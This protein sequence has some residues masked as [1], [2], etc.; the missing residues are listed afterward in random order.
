MSAGEVRWPDA[1]TYAMAARDTDSFFL[2][3]EFA[4]ATLRRSPLGLPLPAT[5]RNAAVFQASLGDGAV[6]VRVFTRPPAQG[7]ERY[8][9]IGQHLRELEGTVFP[10]VQWLSEAVAVE[11]AHW[12]MVRMDWIEGWTLDDWVRDHLDRPD[13]LLDLAQ[14][15]DE[16]FIYLDHSHIAHGDLQHGNV[17]IDADG[18]IKLVDLDGMWIPA[19]EAIPAQEYGHAHFQHPGRADDRIWNARMDG[20]AALLIGISVRALARRPELWETYNDGGNNLIFLADDFEDLER[21]IWADLLAIDDDRLRFRIEKLRR[22]CQE[23]CARLVG[24]L[25]MLNDD[26]PD[27]VVPGVPQW[28][29]AAMSPEPEPAPAPPATE[30]R[31]PVWALALAV[32]AVIVLAVVGVVVLG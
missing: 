14:S 22:A 7:P 23:D 3:P 21:P 16:L 27:A 28:L 4:Q 25:D 19:L 32:V 1:S 17:L 24:P 8:R 18:Q 11:N 20:F 9:L 26:K 6:A 29:S 2:H 15:W 5:G 31:V 13:L 30:D 12:P 10:R